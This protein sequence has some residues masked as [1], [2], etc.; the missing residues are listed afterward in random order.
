[1][2]SLALNSKFLTQTMRYLKLLMIVFI[3][4]ANVYQK[5]GMLIVVFLIQQQ[6]LQIG[7]KYWHNRVAEGL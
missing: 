6:A 3:M 5:Q 2:I 1:M 7:K 4:L